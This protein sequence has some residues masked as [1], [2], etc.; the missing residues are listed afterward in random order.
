LDE[1]LEQAVRRLVAIE[2]IKQLKASYFRCVDGKHWE[3]FATLFTDDLEVDFAESTSGARGRQQWLDAVQRHFDG[4]VSV[5]QGHDPEI[6]ILDEDRATGI[7]PMLDFVEA[8]PGSGYESHKCYGHYH[9]EY[10]RVDGRWRIARTRLSRVKRV[11]L[12]D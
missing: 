5:H 1:T 8:R 7:W 4:S 9:E 11:T 10:R 3:E 6:T 12:P 2:E